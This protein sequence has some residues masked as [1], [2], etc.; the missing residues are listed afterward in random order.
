[1]RIAVVSNMFPD[2]KHPS[3]GVFVR[4]F[5]NI[6]DEIGVDHVN[7]V[8]KKRDSLLGKVFG[9]ISFYLGTIFELMV[10]RYDLIYVHY[11]SHSSI[12]VLITRIFR[13]KPIYTNVHGSD[14]IPENAKQERMQ[15]YTAK[16][17][18][19][20]KVVV[21][22]SEYFKSVVSKKY[23]IR[24]ERIYVSPSGGVDGNIFFKEREKKNGKA[25]QIGY[26][27]RI[28]HKKGWD[29][30]L[31]ACSELTIPYELT[32]VGNGPEYKDMR[33]MAEVLRL[34]T[35]INWQG[36]QPQDQLRGIYNDLDALVFPSERE[37]ESLGLVAI[38]AMACGTPVIAS[39]YAA[40]AYYVVD[41][42]NGFK[43]ECGSSDALA[44]K[45][46]DFYKLDEAEK[47]EMSRAAERTAKAYSVS[48][49]KSGID[50]L[51]ET[52]TINGT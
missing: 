23:G 46:V 4:N 14:V 52:V 34:D 33:E 48:Y 5:C 43:Y 40:Q 36:L 31:K 22:P 32:I 11:A 20:S 12:P 13:K 51:L 30:L 45:I 26:V 6:L 10:G 44:A 41:G 25:L 24:Q 15:K 21:A 28:S 19:I 37:G 50:A 7:F 3:Y 9:Y 29:T 47:R 8:M 16:I 35:N 17:L 18:K 2:E 1:M 39:D 42:E 38:E 27:G 49:I